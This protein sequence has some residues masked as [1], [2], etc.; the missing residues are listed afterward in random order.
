MKIFRFVVARSRTK[1]AFQFFILLAIFALCNSALAV[2]YEIVNLGSLTTGG[3]SYAYSINNDGVI[4]GR[5]QTASGTTIACLFDN[6]GSGSNTN[7]GALAGYSDSYAYS[8][9]DSGQIVGWSQNSSTDTSACSFTTSA[10]SVASIKSGNGMAIAINNAGIT[11]GRYDNKAYNFTTDAQLSTKD[12]YALSINNTGTVVGIE[13]DTG[14]NYFACIFNSG[15]NITLSDLESFAYSINDAG[16]IVGSNEG[17]ACLFDETGGKANTL[18]DGLGSL[19]IAN[20]ISNEIIGYAM[21]SENNAIACM[22]DPTDSG[23][24]INLNDLIDPSLGW[25]LRYAYDINDDGWIV[26]VGILN[27][28]ET[29]YLLKAI[30]EP[31]TIAILGIGGLLFIRKKL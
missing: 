5:A 15:G 31:A 27:G 23:H 9:N 19:A 8:I 17:V 22:F 2:D 16:K 14:G 4:V 3:A 11:V 10:G 13:A 25:N 30:P 20:N 28:T 26:G 18:L 1:S 24:N 12:S 29:A 21:D 7:L 6:T